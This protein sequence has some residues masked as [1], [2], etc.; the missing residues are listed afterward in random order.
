MIALIGKKG[1]WDALKPLGITIIEI[2]SEASLLKALNPDELEKYQIVFLTEDVFSFS[3]KPID[4]WLKKLTSNLILLPD[5]C[6]ETEETKSIAFQKIR[7]TVEK[8]M[9]I[10]VLTN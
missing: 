8:A 6:S 1:L 2:D 3:K 9:G 7:K 4:D 10:D 5:P